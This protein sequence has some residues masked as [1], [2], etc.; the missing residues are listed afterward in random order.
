[1]ASG[2]WFHLPINVPLNLDGSEDTVIVYSTAQL[3]THITRPEA[4]YVFLLELNGVTPEIAFNVNESSS[5]T[6][7]KIVLPPGSGVS[8]STEVCLLHV[9]SDFFFG[10][11]VD[12]VCCSH[13]FV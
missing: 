3:I 8:K 13:L 11:L 2:L 1:M 10:D 9:A 12:D 5:T 7:T 6:T 4:D